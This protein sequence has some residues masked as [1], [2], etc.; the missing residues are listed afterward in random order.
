MVTG[1]CRAVRVTQVATLGDS[2]ATPGT[3]LT[4]LFAATRT[5]CRA[6]VRRW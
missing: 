2:R 5:A 6:S 1:R 4:L 3:A